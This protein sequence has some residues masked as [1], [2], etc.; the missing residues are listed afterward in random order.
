MGIAPLSMFIVPMGISLAVPLIVDIFI[1][2]VGV[3]V[4]KIIIRTVR[5]GK[6]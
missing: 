1:P 6:P 2:T 3:N 4:T 5:G